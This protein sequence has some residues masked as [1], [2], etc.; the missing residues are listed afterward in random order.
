MIAYLATKGQF[1]SDAVGIEDVIRDAVSRELGL[2]I[3]KDSS[4][5]NSWRNSLGNAMFHVLNTPLIPDDAGV[6]IE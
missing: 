4:E 5:Y 2:N 6:A 3:K 1:L